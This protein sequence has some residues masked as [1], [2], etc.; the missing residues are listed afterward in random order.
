MAGNVYGKMADA[1]LGSSVV[2]PCLTAA[3]EA[4]GNC[5]R[6]LGFAAD[7]TRFFKKIVPIRLEPGPFTWSAL[8]TAGLLYTEITQRQTGRARWITLPKRFRVLWMCR[9]WRWLGMLF[10]RKW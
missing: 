4:S 5:K 3:Y 8:I 2:C 7:Q 9:S 10:Q 6:E 1:V